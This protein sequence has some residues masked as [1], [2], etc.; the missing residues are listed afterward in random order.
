MPPR[1]LSRRALNR[2]TLARHLLLRRAK[3]AP[4][5]AIERLVALQAQVARPPFV[6]LWSRIEPFRRDD[7]VRAIEQR[8]V[9]RAT[10]MRGTLHL[11]SRRDFLAF[12]P[13]LQSALSRSSGSTLGDRARGVDSV[14]LIAE[15]RAYFEAQP[16]TFAELRTHLAARF[17]GLDE[18]ALA[19][20][21]RLHLPLIQTPATGAPW[22]YPA[23]ADFAV[24]ESWLGESL[25]GDD[26]RPH[27]LALRYFTAFGPS[28]VQDF[29]AW[30]GIAAARKIVDELGP[31][32]RALRNEDDRELFDA[33][34][35]DYPDD[36]EEAPIRFLPEFDNLLL[37]YADR[38]RVLA[39]EHKPFVFTKNLMVPATFLVDG[40][41]AGTWKVER[42][43]SVT[44]LIV[45]PFGKLTRNAARGL[46]EEGMRLQLFV[47][48]DATDRSV[49]L[50]RGRA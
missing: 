44:K 50:L 31:T 21:V 23:V 43:K 13:T 22:A 30:S 1:K 7:L 29:Q 11:M 48:P 45:E 18:R 41:V 14:A 16:R 8:K 20:I 15:A 47:E 32:L 2:A 12:R 17:A 4:V 6:A 19:Y 24:A 46:E 40:V 34:G 38:R 42:T 37:A 5:A 33:P 9:V 28:T 36:D 39:D 49:S 10:L 25:A 3:L 35:N 27:A 26:N